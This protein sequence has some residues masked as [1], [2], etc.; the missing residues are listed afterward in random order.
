MAK[1]P[2][3]REKDVILFDMI[4]RKRPCSFNLLE[5]KTIDERDL[6]IDE[7]YLTIDRIY[8]MKQ[9][10]GPIFESNM[11]GMF[12]LLMGDNLQEDFFPTILEFP[13]CYLEK[14]FRKCL[15]KKSNDQQAI[16]FIFDQVAR[17]AIGCIRDKF[18]LYEG[19]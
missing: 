12:K 18:Q 10:G 9:T 3:E 11:R 8:D 2:I 16:D 17:K 4:E 19:Q 7:L 6:I 14:D 13:T 15:R 1:G 5:W